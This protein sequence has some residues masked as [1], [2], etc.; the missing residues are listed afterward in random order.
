[1][2]ELTLQYEMVS[3]KTTSLHTACRHLLEEQTPLAKVSQQVQERLQVFNK[4]DKVAQK[5]T[6][7]T[8]SVHS[9]TFFPLLARI[10]ES[11]TYLKKHPS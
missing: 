7:P 11:I 10:D 9:E 8:L 5:L 3:T 4:A 6:S 1:M 2:S